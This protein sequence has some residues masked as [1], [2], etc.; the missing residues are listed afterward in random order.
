MR[1]ICFCLLQ[2]HSFANPFISKIFM[3][4][5]SKLFFSFALLFSIVNICF[6]QIYRGHEA[7]RFI[8]NTDLIKFKDY[9]KVPNYFRFSENITKT[10]YETIEIIKSFITNNNSD[11]Q[12]KHIQ[13]QGDGT[14]TY[15]YYQT[16]H[17]I[18]IEFTA[19]NLQ[20]KG[21]LV[22]AANG[23]ILDNPEITPVF[24]LSETEALQLALNYVN[25]EQYMWEDD[26]E[27]LPT[28]E[29]VIVPDKIDFENSTLKSAYKFNIYSKNPLN[30]Q[31]IYVDAE[32]GEIVLDLPLIHFSNVVGT[33][34]TAYYR[35]RDINTDYTGSQYTLFDATRGNGIHTYDCNDQGEW[36]DNYYTNSTTTWNS[37]P[38]G[39]DAHFSTAA[40][41]DYFFLKH[42]YNSID[43]KGFALKSYVNFSLTK[44]NSFFTNNINAFWDG[45]RMTYGMG[46][47]PSVTAL[48]T[49]DICGH[50]ITHGLISKTAN[51]IYLHESGALN[52]GFS[53][54]FGTAIEY[55]AVPEDANWTIGE[56]MGIIARSVSNPKAYK[57]PDTYKGQYW[58]YNFLFDNGGVHTN[59]GPLSFWFYLLCEGKSGTND[60]GYNYN[61]SA[62]GIEKAE[63]IAFRTLAHYLTPSSSYADA[64]FYGLAA[65]K[66][67]YGECSEEEKAVGNAFY[68]IGVLTQPYNIQAIADFR[69]NI[70]Q[71]CS[72]PQTVQ[73]SNQSSNCNTFVWDF[74]DGSPTS[75][76]QN[77]SH[78]YTGNGVYTVT[79]TGNSNGCGTDTK[80]K[81]NY[82]NVVSNLSN[83]QFKIYDTTAFELFIP[84]AGKNLRWYGNMQENLWETT[85]LFVGN[86]LQHPAISE[87]TTYYILDGIENDDYVGEKTCNANGGFVTSGERN[88]LIFDAYK[89]FV[90]ESVL[91]NASTAGDRTITLENAS[92]GTIWTKTVNIPAGVS[93]I[94]IDKVV[95]IG[96]NMQLV[97]PSF[98]NLY[99]S[100]T[101]KLT[102]PYKIDHVVSI[103]SSS[104]GIPSYYYYFYDWKISNPGCHSNL[105]IVNLVKG[106]LDDLPVLTGTVTVAG[107]AVFGKILT[108]DTQEL[109]CEPLEP[110]SALS[111]Q[112]K[113][114]TDNT[115]TNSPTYTIVQEDI[116][117]KIS[118]TVTAKYCTGA[119]TSPSTATVTKA[120]QTA[121]EA[122]ELDSVTTTSITL[123]VVDGCEYRMESG[124]WEI[125]PVFSGLAPASTYTFTQRLAE[126]ITHF[127]SP[128]S[129]EATFKTDE[130]V[131]IGEI[132]S[133][134]LRIYPNPTTGEFKVQGFNSSKVQSIEIFD[135]Y[136]R[137]VGGIFPSNV[138][139]G[140]TQADGVVI[141]ISHLQKGI[142][143]VKIKTEQG[144]VTKKIIKN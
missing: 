52:E 50:E 110:L 71:T 24:R 54:I 118:V 101:T 94:T 34:K 68:A 85:P 5:K 9:S 115:G 107:D 37:T 56:K 81:Q 80:I 136:G 59:C 95:P 142:Y 61:V 70:T 69:A 109:T 102:Y 48:T 53:D 39:T 141:N 28:G 12:L 57:M 131:G 84:E 45:S 87:D 139:E 33:A 117:K 128:E 99:R 90:L 140:W 126:T 30:R 132:T 38:Y 44:Y 119:V 55:F 86:P 121:P 73:F 14:Q 19:L 130:E 46:N 35:T 138:L 64:C 82:I 29:K 63:K 58:D 25:A 123:I 104:A 83:H 89:D 88:Y 1:K 72:T 111:F 77:P 75:S 47:P 8:Q 124:N 92:G 42:G 62:I 6:S 3:Y 31:M 40:T 135:I 112:W 79:L 113:S 16:V 108:A 4:M 114:D 27:Y 93:R 26:D 137:E 127:A 106:S 10:E 120:T 43:N 49:M 122:P 32:N 76:L 67:L 97:G 105:G 116:D 21:N 13:N 103:K 74:G 143:F 66:D 15:R 23:E 133:Y 7:N 100:F 11:L 20:V 36:L 18:P 65:A 17:G 60:L 2:N 125:S 129:M 91:V 78:T 134:E 41:Y 22:T 51:L 98:P 96:T 144:I